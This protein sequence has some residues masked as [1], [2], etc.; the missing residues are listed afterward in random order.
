MAIYPALFEKGEGGRIV[1]SFPDLPGCLTE[2][3]TESEAMAMAIDAL[4]GHIHTLQD[5]K[6]EVPA[7]SSLSDAAVP[8][9]ARAALVPGPAEDSPPVRINISINQRL[10]RDVDEVAKREGMTRS[11]LLAAAARSMLAQLRA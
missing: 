5:L 3:D 2:G 11:G 10:L 7:P 9:G 1:V 8:E 4:S 6:R